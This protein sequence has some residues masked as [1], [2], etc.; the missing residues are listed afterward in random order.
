MKNHSSR[1]RPSL[2]Q[3]QAEDLAGKRWSDSEVAPSLEL[4]ADEVAMRIFAIFGRPDVAIRHAGRW[5]IQMD[6]MLVDAH[7]LLDNYRRLPSGKSGTLNRSAGSE[8]L[9]TDAVLLAGRSG[10]LVIERLQSMACKLAPAILD[11]LGVT[12]KPR[13]VIVRIAEG[14]ETAGLLVRDI[15]PPGTERAWS[16]SQLA[17][18]RVN[19]IVR[20]RWQSELVNR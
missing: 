15:G 3:A 5:C 4:F 12:E 11:L 7:R 2:S 6:G 19:Q 18:A 8:A 14:L 20:P 17:R 1:V 10:T 9:A 16:L 13:E